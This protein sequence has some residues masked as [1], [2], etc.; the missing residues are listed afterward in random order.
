[1][2][3]QDDLQK[4]IEAHERR[5]QE[6]ELQQARTGYATEPSITLEIEDITAKLADLYPQLS[7][8]ATPSIDP[9]AC[10][11]ATSSSATLPTLSTA[12]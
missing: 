11:E 12:P 7:D 5:L 9:P 4:Q 8:Q 3:Q 2:P 1:M 6:L 10:C